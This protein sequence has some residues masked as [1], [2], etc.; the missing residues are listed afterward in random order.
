ME[1]RNPFLPSEAEFKASHNEDLED[2][3][4]KKESKK[5]KSRFAELLAK[6]LPKNHDTENTNSEQGNEK[7]SFLEKIVGRFGFLGVEK[8]EVPDKDDNDSESASA[9]EGFLFAPLGVEVDDISLDDQQLNNSFDET[10]QKVASVNGSE[11]ISVP[12]G[13]SQ[14]SENELPTM[15]GNIAQEFQSREDGRALIDD[16]EESIFHDVHLESSLPKPDMAARDAS[17]EVIQQPVQVKER[18][19]V[20]ERSGGGG[21][22]LLGFVAAETLSRSR[23][24]KIRQEAAELREQIEKLEEKQ[25]YTNSYLDETRN[26]NREQFNELRKRGKEAPSTNRKIETTNVTANAKKPLQRPFVAPETIKTREDTLE[27][28]KELKNTTTERSN[29]S[30]KFSVFETYKEKKLVLE[31]I[32]KAAEQDIALESFYE[33]MHEVKDV[34]T[35]NAHG[36]SSGGASRPNTYSFGQ[37]SGGQAHGSYQDN[38]GRP[39]TKKT[40]HDESLYKNAAKQGAVAGVALVIIFALLALVWSLF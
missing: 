2:G 21:A 26:K 10:S 15:Y 18:E 35:T 14:V 13:D 16:D 33:K 12:L 24:K 6:L 36:Q 40:V 23:D 20:I 9:P 38:L 31:Q 3:S 25:V 17:S 22:A 1:D 27:K 28:D 7:H 39:H 11:D 30:E 8:E 4:D 19:T 5:K 32:E 34:P 37:V 29:T